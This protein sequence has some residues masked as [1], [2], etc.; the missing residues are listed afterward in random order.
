M[1]C[2]LC[3]HT[4]CSSLCFRKYSGKCFLAY[5]NNVLVTNVMAV[6]VPSISNKMADG[7]LIPTDAVFCFFDF[8][9]GIEFSSGF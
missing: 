7:R 1:I 2:D 4:F 6:V 3:V 5:G 8:G 9:C